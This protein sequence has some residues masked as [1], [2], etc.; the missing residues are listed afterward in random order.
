MRSKLPSDNVGR[1]RYSAPVITPVYCADQI[2][3]FSG[4]ERFLGLGVPHRDLGLFPSLRI[5]IS[6]VDLTVPSKVHE[7]GEG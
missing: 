3:C 7:T 2:N 4:Q 5:P 6:V 1:Q